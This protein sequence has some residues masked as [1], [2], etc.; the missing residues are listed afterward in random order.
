MSQNL[1]RSLR[2]SK[3]PVRS[4]GGVVAAQNQKAADIGASVLRSGGNAIDAAVATAFSLAVLEPWMS[5]IGGGGFM[6]VWD[7]KRKKAHVIDYGMISAAALHPADYPLAEGVGGDLFGWPLVVD[8][9]NILGYPSIAVPG[10][11]EGMR[12][13]L[14]SFGTR[15]WQQSL[16]PAIE[17]A[18]E[19]IEVD[20]FL[21]M[22]VTSAAKDL[23]RFPASRA[24]FL[25]DGLP[26]SADWAGVAPRLKNEA[27]L[28][29][30][31]RL[32]AAGARD[33]YEGELAAKLVRDLQAGGSKIA[34]SDLA[35]YRARLVEPLRYTHGDKT[36]LLPPGL[37]AGP[38]LCDALE[39]AAPK[40][41]G[42]VLS[43]Q[44]FVAYAEG[45]TASYEKR[46]AGMGDDNGKSCTTHFCVIDGEGNM[47]ALTQ[48]LLSLFGSRVMLPESGVL[49]NNGIMWFDPRP[50]RPNSLGPAK[51][52]LSNMLP[53]LV[54]DGDEPWL[55]IGASGGR[56]IMPAV[57]QLLSFLIDYRMP[58]ADAFHQ[59][60][61]D[62]SIPGQPFCD[63]LL[64][65]ATRA[66]V[67]A[68]FPKAGEKRR[69]PFPLAYAC[70]SAVMIE[71]D[72]NRVGMT[73][74]AQPWAGMAGA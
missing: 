71:S 56:R 74:I 62:A 55:A 27:L 24:M 73:E 53:T 33:Y 45:L 47:V 54:L 38:S 13:A 14:E 41:T 39:V 32:S 23:A 64:D 20:W 3:E 48:T 61:I 37:T 44:S 15:N 18:R 2:Y 1:S 51:R 36:L 10:Q 57:M 8:D 25:P 28:A 7:A 59:P 69:D 58:L 16:G 5:G 11:P 68:R 12:L 63:P 60:R 65:E 52:P 26:P 6:V 21:S 34:A 9:R 22:V 46:L 72:G 42:G 19:G 49:M 29:S 67:R 17:V 66:A 4:K 30:L 43:P 70:P 40:L 31:Q 35:G 50:G